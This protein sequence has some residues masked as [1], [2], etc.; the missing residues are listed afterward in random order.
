MYE[1]KVVGNGPRA[2]HW[3]GTPRRRVATNQTLDTLGWA[4]LEPGE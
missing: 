3:L 1:T 2:T 4:I